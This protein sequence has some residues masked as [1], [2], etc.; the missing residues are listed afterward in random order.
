MRPISADNV[1]VC[2]CAQCGAVCTRDS[3]AIKEFGFARLGGRMGDRPYCSRCMR[4]T[5]VS[6]GKSSRMYHDGNEF[7]PRGRNRL[8][9]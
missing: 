3:L 2:N 6:S 1:K 9:L 8:S 5:V 4:S 7:R